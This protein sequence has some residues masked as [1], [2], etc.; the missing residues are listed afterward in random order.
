MRG[1]ADA[2]HITTMR[3][4]LMKHKHT[5]QERLFLLIFIILIVC[6]GIISLSHDSEFHYLEHLDET[7]VT[8][9]GNAIPLRELGFYIIYQETLGD[10]MAKEY[11]TANHNIFWSR[12]TNGTFVSTHAREGAIS[13]AVHDEIFYQEALLHEYELTEEEQDIAERRLQN[14]LSAITVEQLDAVALTEESVRTTIQKIALAEKYMVAYAQETGHYYEEFHILGDAYKALLQ[15][16]NV[17]ENKYL[18]NK[19]SLGKISLAK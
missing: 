11:D 15:E 17:K 16:H 19:L 6:I 18:I 14:F 2:H 7:V 10:S 4:I 12:R 5:K 13:M 8:V 1:R 3:D 9:D